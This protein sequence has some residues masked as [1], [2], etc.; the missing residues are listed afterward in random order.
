M[1]TYDWY[2]RCDSCGYYL[3]DGYYHYGCTSDNT[4]P[5][6]QQTTTT[7]RRRRRH[8]GSSRHGSPGYHIR[9]YI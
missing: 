7:Y 2:R 3:P 6:V 9:I 4:Y 8:H 5:V 1:Y